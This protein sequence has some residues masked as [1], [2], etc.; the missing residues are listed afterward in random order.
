MLNLHS[1]I[2]MVA[3][4]P[5]SPAAVTGVKLNVYSPGPIPLISMAE[6]PGNSGSKVTSIST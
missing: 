6:T 4:T 3:G 2:V 1:G 5:L